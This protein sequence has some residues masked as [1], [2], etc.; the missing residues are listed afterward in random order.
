MTNPIRIMAA[1][2]HVL[3]RRGIAAIIASQP[4]MSLVAEASNDAKPS[5]SIERTAPT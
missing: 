1:D 5:S 2:D 3:L 4:D